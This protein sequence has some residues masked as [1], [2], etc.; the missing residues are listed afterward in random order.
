MEPRRGYPQ[1]R[2]LHLSCP[3]PTPTPMWLDTLD[4]PCRRHDA[5][6]GKPCWTN[7]RACCGHRV[8]AM[9]ARH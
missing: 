3:F 6:P 2:N 9:L 7:V 4:L 5:D 8:T 1:V